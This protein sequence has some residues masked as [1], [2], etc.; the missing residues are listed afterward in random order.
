MI[1]L[2][3][4]LLIFIPALE[5]WGLITVGKWIGGFN[6]FLIVILTGIL[7]A[8]L[9]KQQGIQVF[10]DAH[11]RMLEGEAPGP[12]I[13]NGIAVLIGGV[14]LLTPGFFSDVIGIV[15]LLPPTR[16]IFTYFLL[17]WIKKKIASGT[18]Y[19]NGRRW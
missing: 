9:A 15:L 10:Q 3:I 14:M 17:E 4:L 16:K 11:R 2:F 8:Y 19:I 18:I 12:A 7:G 13:L 6:T 1:R 5:I